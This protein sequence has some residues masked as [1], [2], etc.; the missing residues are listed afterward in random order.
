MYLALST[1]ICQFCKKK[2]KQHTIIC[3]HFYKSGCSI[4]DDYQE[5]Q[6]CWISFIAN[7]FFSLFLIFF[8]ACTE[9]GKENRNR[10]ASVAPSAFMSYHCPNQCSTVHSSAP[11][12]FSLCIYGTKTKINLV[13]YN[14]M[15]R[16]CY[17]NVMACGK[18]K[19]RQ[20]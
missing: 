5:G 3:H 15:C 13:L 2:K 1:N 17:Q 19:E 4:G 9:K 18:F 14:K 11:C 8:N 6:F 12:T 7:V 10:S 16:K 20:Q